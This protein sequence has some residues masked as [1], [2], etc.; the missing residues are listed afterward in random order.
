MTNHPSHLSGTKEVVSQSGRET[1]TLA[2]ELDNGLQVSAED[3]EWKFARSGG[4]GG[5]HVNTSDTKVILVCRLEH[6]RGPV[7]LVE[8]VQMN[9]GS[10]S[11]RVS[12]SSNRSQWR[13]R[14][15]ATEQM[16]QQLLALSENV[17][18]RVPTRIPFASKRRRVEDK[19]HASDKKRLRRQPGS[20]D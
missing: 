5:Q 10:D 8:R 9:A 7:R 19:R 1:M 12:V 11:L 6:L 3:L 2:I 16:K 18:P 17:A 20:W 4:P 14:I 13:N 15:E